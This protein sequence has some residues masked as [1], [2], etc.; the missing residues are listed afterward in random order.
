MAK[1]ALK[2]SAPAPG[3]VADR[4]GPD[5]SVA[6]AEAYKLLRTNLSYAFPDE[7][8]NRVI[9]LTSPMWDE[10]KALAAVNLAYVMAEA[11][12]RVLLIEGDMRVPALA[13][14]LGFSQEPGLVDLLSGLNNI[15]SAIQS[16]EVELDERE[17][18]FDVIVAG[19]VPPD[20]S[21]L[22]GSDRMKNLL[23]RLRER[24]DYVLLELPP[25]G[26][27]ADASVAA[28][29]VDG[30][31]VTVAAE[32]TLRGSLSEA[33]RRLRLANANILGFVFSGGV[34]SASKYNRG[35]K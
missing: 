2:G 7:A 29:V 22:L 15:G 14:M 19:A 17:I 10:G 34:D 18:G 4:I 11:D 8:A 25:A 5:M 27:V 32:Q 20:P 24:Y 16:Y 26:A 33:M 21:E 28:S 35:R 30:M 12:K 1:K 13:G 9:G 31:V 3:G 23:K 6:E